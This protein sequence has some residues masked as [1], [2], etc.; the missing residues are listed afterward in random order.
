MKMSLASFFVL[1]LVCAVGMTA[2][3]CGGN[4]QVVRRDFSTGQSLMLDP[5]TQRRAIQGTQSTMARFELKQ[6]AAVPAHKHA[7]EQI[8]YVLSGKVLMTVG[9]MAFELGAG[10]AIVVPPNVEHSGMATTDA[11][12]LEFFAPRREDFSGPST[13]E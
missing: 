3:G 8:T 11:V 12:T 5:L 1:G 9:G 13:T 2:T 6:G 4:Q 7:N 10:E